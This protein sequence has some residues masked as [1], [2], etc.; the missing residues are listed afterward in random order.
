MEASR[1]ERE[2]E[3]KMPG[4]EREE[5]RGDSQ[6]NFVCLFVCLFPYSGLRGS[7]RGGE[8]KP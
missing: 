8:M 3:K 7:S 4:R 5:T 2:G 1:G 6:C